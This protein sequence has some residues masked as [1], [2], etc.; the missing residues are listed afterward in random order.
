MHLLACGASRSFPIHNLVL[1]HPI[2][3]K[4]FLWLSLNP[5]E[6][7]SWMVEGLPKYFQG[8]HEKENGFRDQVVA[9]FS[10]PLPPPAIHI[11]PAHEVQ[12]DEC[13]V[14]DK[15]HIDHSRFNT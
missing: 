2:D 1:H 12:Q 6:K 9:A 5:V 10:R 15:T 3:E 14:C 7:P 8:D 13:G 11:Q 4:S